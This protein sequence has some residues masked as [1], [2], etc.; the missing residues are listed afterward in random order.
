ML[1]T[2][3]LYNL[4][5][6]NALDDPSLKVEKWA[7]E[8]LRLL[9]LQELF[10]RLKND[11]QVI[12]DRPSFHGFAENCETPEELTDLLLSEEDENKLDPF[13][14][15]IFELWRR[16]LPEKQSLSIFCDEMD[17]RISLYDKAE[18]DELIQ[19]TLLNLIDVLDENVEAGAEPKEVF[20]AICD[21]CANDIES[22]LYD[23]ITD[24]LNSKEALYALELINSFSPYVEDL[25]LF[26][27]DLK[28]KAEQ[29]LASQKDVFLDSLT[30]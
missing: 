12:L 19:E 25:A 21:Y 13:Y 8:D 1:Q 10:D 29:L 24:L 30:E 7:L 16:L 28:E 17:Y 2:K 9:S 11:Y 4:L 18:N 22:F 26:E 5:R 20:A 3:A 23:Y 27:K 6:L 15:L 14:L